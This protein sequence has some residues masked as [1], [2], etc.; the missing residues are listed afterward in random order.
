MQPFIPGLSDKKAILLEQLRSWHW[1]PSTD[2]AFQWLKI[3][4]YDQ[5]LKTTLTFFNWDPT[6]VIQ[7]Y[8]SEYSLGAVSLKEVT[9]QP[10]PAN[11]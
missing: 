9:Q 5:L 11:P 1:N 4:I 3:W 2:A 7:N 6:E 10:S 8:A